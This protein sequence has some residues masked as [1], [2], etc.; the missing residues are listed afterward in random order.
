M[1]YIYWYVDKADITSL[2]EYFSTRVSKIMKTTVP[3][4]RSYKNIF[5]GKTDNS[6]KEQNKSYY[7]QKKEWK[8]N[9]GIYIECLAD[10][11]IEVKRIIKK[12]LASDH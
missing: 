3:I 2:D 4:A 7:I 6:N 1:E 9:K 11:T 5:T 10:H 8:P 12:I